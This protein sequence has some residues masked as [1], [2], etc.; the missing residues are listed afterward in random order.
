MT[1]KENL[2]KSYVTT[3][4]RHRKGAGNAAEF[5]RR[6]RAYQH[7]FGGFLPSNK[8]AK[9]LDLGCGPGSIVWWLQNRG[10]TN[11]SGIDISHEQVEIAHGLGLNTVIQGDIFDYLKRDDTQYDLLFGRDVLEH[12]DKESVYRFLN[13]THNRLA[14]GGSLILQIPNAESPFFGRIRYGDFT[15]ELAFTPSSIKQ[16]GYATGFKTVRAFPVR[17][18]VTGIRSAIR[19]F[20]WLFVEAAIKWVV[21]LESPGAGTVV[22]TNILVIATKS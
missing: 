20:F 4:I 19:R 18:V 6:A 15:H 12:L 21:R 16:L 17:P 7:V 13:L 3:H 8:D 5:H 11:V 2:Y 22:T 9:V 10:Y 1:Y 14:S